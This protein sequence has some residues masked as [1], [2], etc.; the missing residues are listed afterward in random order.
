MQTQLWQIPNCIRSY[1]YWY[2]W[3][4]IHS[5]NIL[6]PFNH[7]ILIDRLETCLVRQIVTIDLISWNYSVPKI[8]QYGVQ[9]S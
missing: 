6:T 9:Q 1:M 4:C 3:T 5:C 7:D 2:Y 8:I